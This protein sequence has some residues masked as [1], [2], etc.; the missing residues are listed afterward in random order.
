MPFIDT[1]TAKDPAAERQAK[2]SPRAVLGGSGLKIE[3]YFLAGVI[4]QPATPHVLQ[5]ADPEM[6]C[7]SPTTTSDE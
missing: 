5:I 4:Y 7:L 1:V 6:T 2:K 3:T